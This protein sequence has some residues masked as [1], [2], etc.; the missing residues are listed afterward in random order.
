MI[1][2]GSNFNG[3]EFAKNT[4]ITLLRHLF[5]MGADQA[6]LVLDDENVQRLLNSNEKFDA[7]IVEVF[8][9]D[10]LLGLGQHF[11]CPVIGVNT[12][13]GVY[14]NDVYTGKRYKFYNKFIQ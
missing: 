2:D 1:V 12:F 11:N 13:D 3:F 5:S 14:W 10:S 9:I 4:P 6:E 7:V 8:A